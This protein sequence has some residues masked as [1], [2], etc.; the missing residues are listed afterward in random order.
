MDRL[1]DA[2]MT[3]IAERGWRA[4]SFTDI[5]QS[6]GLVYR[7]VY[8]EARD[9]QA[10]MEAFADRMDARMLQEAEAFDGA[11]PVRELLFDLIMARFDAL[12]DYK[13]ALAKLV[14]EQQKA[15]LDVISTLLRLERSMALALEAAGETGSGL[16]GQLRAK[17]LTGLYLRCLKAWLKDDSEDLG[18][19][20]KILDESLAQAERA[21]DLLAKGPKDF[22]WPKRSA[23][24]PD[25]GAADDEAREGI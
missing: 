9:K 14:E 5:L 19:T 24:E 8:K 4:T 2:A 17:A 18:P 12:A 23:G 25:Q 21:A 1:I 20:M 3:L 11:T 22:S 15:P 6:A 10:V 7:D 13:P 16:A